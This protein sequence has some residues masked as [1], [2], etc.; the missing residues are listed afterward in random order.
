MEDEYVE[1]YDKYCEAPSCK[2]DSLVEIV[3]HH[4]ATDGAP[5]MQPNRQRPAEAFSASEDS[6]WNPSQPAQS[7]SRQE[8][9]NNPRSLPQAQPRGAS[10]MPDK[11][12]IYSFFTSSFELITMVS[13][14]KEYRV[15]IF[16]ELSRRC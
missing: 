15:Q 7:S 10:S 3:Q 14:W 16:S 11:I 12:V 2:L 8:Q 5:G 4:L 9:Q 1:K 13:C 6:P